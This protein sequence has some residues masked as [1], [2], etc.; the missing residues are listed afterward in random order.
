MT[1][2]D[3]V[4]IT[5]VFRNCGGYVLAISQ[6]YS[7]LQRR[8]LGFDRTH[9]AVAFAPTWFKPIDTVNPLLRQFRRYCSSP[10]APFLFTGSTERLPPLSH[11]PT[12]SVSVV[13]DE[14][15]SRARRHDR[16]NPGVHRP[17][18]RRRS[19]ARLRRRGATTGCRCHSSATRP[20]QN[21]ESTRSRA[22]VVR[23]LRHRPS[24]A[25]SGCHHGAARDLAASSAGTPVR[26]SPSSCLSRG[27]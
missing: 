12:A 3:S 13:A 6:E 24:E 1:D 27:S 4:E 26:R 14:R 10:I 25:R 15:G 5:F 9:Q 21:P 20:D 19:Q 22:V 11:R 17:C 7:R 2:P 23:V 18:A 16:T 8:C